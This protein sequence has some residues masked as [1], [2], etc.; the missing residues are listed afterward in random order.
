MST[1]IEQR[2]E[3]V[4]ASQPALQHAVDCEPL[5]MDLLKIAATQESRSDRWQRYEA[6]KG[7]GSYLVGWQARQSSLQT[8]AAYIAYIA[9]IDTLLPEPQYED[10][11][12]DI[13]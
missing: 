12:D 9:A 5:V 13:A 3:Q 4:L 10:E 2:I 6:L 1:E 7:M 11:E 8:E